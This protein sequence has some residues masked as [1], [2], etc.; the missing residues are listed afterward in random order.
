MPSH[1]SFTPV[2]INVSPTWEILPPGSG[3]P[4]ILQDGGVGVDPTPG[5]L[6]VTPPVD[7]GAGAR[8]RAAMAEAAAERAAGAP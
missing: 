8:D 6:V 5:R 3:V 7:P 1:L 2:L 4:P